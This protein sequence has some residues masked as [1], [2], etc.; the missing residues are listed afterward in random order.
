M[1]IFGFSGQ[2]TV[3]QTGA[4]S[5]GGEANQM[6][7]IADI[8]FRDPILLKQ[9]NNALDLY[10]RLE[11]NFPK[12]E[13]G[14]RYGVQL[15]KNETLVGEKV[16]TEDVLSVEGNSSIQKIFTYEA[17]AYLS[18][19]YDLWLVA[20]NESGLPLATFKLEKSLVLKGDGE[21]LEIDQKSCALK[22]DGEA[23]DK[24]YSLMQG[25]SLKAEETLKLSCEAISRFK[26]FTIV[27][28]FFSTYERTLFGNLV[29]RDRK[30]TEVSFQMGEKKTIEFT[31]EKPTI[32]QAYEARLDLMRTSG[33]IISAAAPIIF[34]YVIAG[35][36]AT[37]QKLDLDNVTYKKGDTINAT[38]LWSGSADNF[39]GSQTGK[40]EEGSML[41]S[42]SIFNQTGQE[43]ANAVEQKL[44]PNGEAK[45]VLM[46]KANCVD[47]KVKVVL[48]NERGAVLTQKEF[49]FLKDKE[50]VPQKPQTSK[51]TLSI[52]LFCGLI[53][54]V[55]LFFFRKRNI[56]PAKILPL[57]VLFLFGLGLQRAE[58]L[59]LY[60]PYNSWGDFNYSVN[61]D[62]GSY[63]SGDP[64]T[65]SYS[66]TATNTGCFD[67]D[68]NTT[69]LALRSTSGNWVDVSWRG[70]QDFRNANC[71]V[72]IPN[73]T[74]SA[75][76]A[77][78]SSSSISFKACITGEGSGGVR[79]YCSSTVSGGGNMDIATGDIP[80]SVADNTPA[81]TC[82]ISFGSSTYNVGDWGALTWTNTN[83]TGASLYCTIGSTVIAN[84]SV[85]TSNTNAGVQLTAAGKASCVLTVTNGSKSS[86]CYTLPTVVAPPPVAPLPTG[87][88]QF[89][90]NKRI[91]KVG[92]SGTVQ[93]ETKNATS[94]NLHCHG[95]SRNGSQDGSP[96]DVIGPEDV[97]LEGTRGMRFNRKGFV[98]CELTISNGVEGANLEISSSP[99]YDALANFGQGQTAFAATSVAIALSV[100]I[101]V[102][103]CV[104]TCSGSCVMN[105]P[106]NGMIPTAGECCNATM[107]C[108]ACP[109]NTTWDGLTCASPTPTPTASGNAS[110]S[111]S[112]LTAPGTSKLSWNSTDA[113][114]VWAYCTGPLP[115]PYGNYGLSY[116]IDGGV[117]FPFAVDQTGVE[118]CTFKP[119][120]NGVLG[121]IFSASVNVGGPTCSGWTLSLLANP[122]SGSAPLTSV[123]TAQ[124]NQVFGGETYLYSNQSC[125]SGGWPVIS[126]E[127]FTCTYPTAG[128][129]QPS[130]RVTAQSTGC[131]NDAN[132]TV[133]VNSGSCTIDCSC[134][135]ST[136]VNET[137]PD[138]CTGTCAGTKTDG[139]CCA[140][141]IPS[142]TAANTCVGDT[143]NDGCNIISGTKPKTCLPI[144]CDPGDCGMKTGSGTCGAVCPDK[145][146]G[147]CNSGNWQEVAS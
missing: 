131:T 6:T 105:N 67:H 68:G 7:V 49:N 73:Y 27:A 57:L 102:A 130:I 79:E 26:E 43:C 136:C 30:G 75:G 19:E 66:G 82:N 118:T 18:G 3:A 71:S 135:S 104:N 38:L 42:L 96:I 53:V 83:A 5:S 93:W 101:E 13:A 44:E 39:I 47:P 60:K 143:C 103:E 37:I 50:V 33:N 56:N 58:A 45:L 99:I 146:C 110:F 28:P 21:Y 106:S 12:S 16:Y 128:T 8:N 20:K 61:L 95:G 48:K 32:S 84:G 90:D 29:D 147:P 100:T 31:I 78:S 89:V 74:L 141:N 52:F 122:V 107:A 17:P 77:P 127:K 133:T 55:V 54:L 65:V 86:T 22:I 134:A 98:I 123:L 70:N 2:V 36:S 125:G 51:K 97:Q 9:E 115:I 137:C 15:V 88:I 85:A 80:Y 69:L 94:A 34:H 10:F 4:D 41:L 114:E 112:A 140:P 117:A 121:T 76:N 62:K 116:N 24:K 46:A 92:Q 120:K 1:L 35:E 144:T 142:C 119:Y 63:N 23:G 91:Y 113:D 124:T 111:P 72:S 14:I 145:D 87:R 11:N 64:I 25:V 59:T 126:G 109:P 129:Y 138:G 132:A 139:A 40:S 81:P 108:Y